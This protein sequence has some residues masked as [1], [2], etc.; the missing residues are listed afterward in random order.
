MIAPGVGVA[1]AGMVG[2]GVGR[3]DRDPL[4]VSSPALQLHRVRSQ[5]SDHS[6]DNGYK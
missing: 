3:V 2:E 4:A 6:P 1:D 5:D